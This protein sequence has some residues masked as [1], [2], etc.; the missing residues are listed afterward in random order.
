MLN[1]QTFPI[2]DEKW[3]TIHASVRSDRME[4]SIFDGARRIKRLVAG[5]DRF[6]SGRAGLMTFQSIW[7]FRNMHVTA[8]DGQTLWDGSR[9]A[10]HDKVGQ[11]A[12]AV[13]IG[14]RL[15][16]QTRRGLHQRGNGLRAFAARSASSSAAR[17]STVFS[18]SSSRWLQF[19]QARRSRL[20]GSGAGFRHYGV[21]TLF[22]GSPHCSRTAAWGDWFAGGSTRRH[23]NR[24]RG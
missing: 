2:E 17:R 13:R 12:S 7:R 9:M 22:P 24:L 19:L 23:S 1:E 14:V 21:I 16:R 3:Y 18:S 15:A 8:A 5:D 10:K 6:P 20:T 4:A 11:S